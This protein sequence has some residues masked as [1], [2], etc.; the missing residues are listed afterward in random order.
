MLLEAAVGELMDSPFLRRIEAQLLMLRAPFRTGLPRQD[1]LTVFERNFMIADLG[2]VA[3]LPPPPGA[4]RLEILN[5]SEGVEEETAR[6]IATAYQDHIDAQVNDQYR[7]AAGARR[8]LSNIIQY[9][10]CGS[11]LPE[12][13]FLA[14]ERG[15]G[16][17]IGVCLSS[18][19]AADAGHITQ[20]CVAPDW[21]GRGAG[22][23][24]MRRA[25]ASLAACGCLR[26]SLTVTAANQKAVRL[27]ER[28][29]FRTLRRFAAYVWDGF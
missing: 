13:S 24:L 10:G 6:L 7:S 23:E 16:R 19:V 5:W 25:L 4:G 3:A 28:I 27:Y 8:F 11:F 12:A 26:A 9:P 21:K 29:G 18:R 14:F 15:A 1:Y 22:Y 20:V 2:D 17:L